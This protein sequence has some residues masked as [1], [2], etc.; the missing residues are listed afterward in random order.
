MKPCAR[1]AVIVIAL[2]AMAGWAQ[3]PAERFTKVTGRL[4]EAI[5]A[6]DYPGTLRDFSKIML[7][8]F[9]R[10]KAEP[11]FQ[12]LVAGYGKITRLGPPRLTPPNQAVFPAFCERG[13]LDIRIVLDSE[14]KIAGL[15]FTPH[16]ADIPVPEKHVTV[17]RL[18]FAGRWTV[19][20]GGD[21]RELNQHHDAINQ[22]YAFDFVVTDEQGKSC[23][24]DG[25]RNEDYYAFGREILAP[26]DGVVTDVIEGVRDNQPGSMNPYSAVGNA[27][28]V[29]HRD[30]E[31][32]VFAHLRQGS[33]RVKVGEAVKTGQVLGLCGN[34][35]NSSEPHLHYHLQNTS[36]IQDGTGIKCFFDN[37]SLTR[38]GKTSLEQ[39]CSPIKG[40]M[41]EQR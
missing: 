36:I 41:V 39:R 22:R 15:R 31:V 38:G 12:G 30:Y 35:G 16:V 13:V 11:F 7:D 5:N 29:R 19:V 40:D 24:N 27:V 2:L 21:T 32:S 3:D 1:F 28:F 9:P 34:S 4:V 23:R 37:V 6:G 26:A 33:I 17:F 10:E 25:T 18:P 20:W 8:A 14:D